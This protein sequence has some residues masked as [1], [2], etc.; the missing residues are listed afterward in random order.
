MFK[1]SVRDWLPVILWCS[2]IFYL[3]S[4]PNLK[5]ELGTWDTILRKIAHMV[6]YAVLF[7]LV[8]RAIGN[9]FT[10]LPA[11]RTVLL[12][13]VFSVVYAASDEF[14]QSFVPTRGPSVAD[15]GIDVLGVIA[16]FAVFRAVRKIGK[17]S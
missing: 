15:V 1:R 13:F 4:V 2:L 8:R 9:S 14:H 11:A 5:T 16:G 10:R 17:V 12:A 3:S 7:L 6:E